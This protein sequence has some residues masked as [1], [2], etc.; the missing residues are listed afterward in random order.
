MFPQ[1][2]R[3]EVILLICIKAIALTLIYYV[4]VAPG[5]VFCMMLPIEEKPIGKLEPSGV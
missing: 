2:T 4:F 1:S 5:A 3:R